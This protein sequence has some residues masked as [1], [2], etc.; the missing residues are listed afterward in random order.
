MFRRKPAPDLIRAGHRFADKNMRHART[1]APMSSGGHILLLWSAVF[2]GGVVSGFSGFAFAAIA[3]AILIHVYPP[4]AAIP[5]L[6]ACGFINQII[7]AVYLRASIDWRGS[8]PFAIG[9]GLGL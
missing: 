4:M 7:S 9:G 3:G 8:L 6:M 1:C 5:L 2:L